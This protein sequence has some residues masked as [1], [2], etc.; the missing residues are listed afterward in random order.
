MPEV[1]HCLD[2]IQKWTHD[3]RYEIIVVDNNSTDRSFEG[4]AEKYPEVRFKLLTSNNGFG[5]GS[6]IGFALSRGRFVCFLNPDTVFVENSLPNGVEFLQNHDKVG[7][8][9]FKMVDQESRPQFGFG[10]LPGVWNEILYTTGLEMPVRRKVQHSRF[11]LHLAEGKPFRVDWVA[12]A[13]MLVRRSM[14]E[15]VGGFDERF[16]LFHEDIDLCARCGESGWETY[17]LP[18]TSV[19]HSAGHSTRRN[20]RLLITSRYHSK[21]LYARKHLSPF[22]REFV[23]VLSVMGLLGRLLISLVHQFGSDAERIGRRNGY[24]DS[25]ILCLKNG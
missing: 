10:M 9:S 13:C 15:Q 11:G 12:G 6:N 14:L 1:V 18:T 20:L 5:A 19:V 25:L 21:L 3:V 23:R 2:S 17:Y 8:L 7:I 22:S 4:L 24:W 16:F